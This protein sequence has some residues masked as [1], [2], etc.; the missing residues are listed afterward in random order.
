MWVWAA[1]AVALVL[2]A[3]PAG[4]ATLPEIPADAERY[5]DRV[6][7]EVKVNR[8]L[9]YG[10][11][12]GKSGE[13]EELKL[14]LYRPQGDRVKRR[15]A[16]I[17]AHGGGFSGG[18]KSEG[19]SPILARKF[20][21]MG[22]VTASINY[23]LLA[24]QGQCGGSADVPP[25]CYSAAIEAVNDGQAA[26]RFLR[27]NAKRFGVGRQ[28]VG[29]GGESA[30][31]ILAN[32]VAAYNEDPGSSGNPGYSSAVQGFMSLSGGLPD[33]VFVDELTAPGLLFASTADPVVPY[34]W[35]VETRDK[36]QSFGVPVR[37]T[38]FESDVH[39]PF[40]QYRSKILRQTTKYMYRYLDVANAP[41]A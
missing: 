3:A 10:S 41:G 16:L 23:R 40:E 17:F 2:L 21:R 4:A 26:V 22:Y 30:G 6:F 25:E 1:L 20:A 11:A 34:E 31:A 32:G 27:A 5:R 29:I 8:D 7:T 9:V 36:M 35:S 33:G 13:P 15:P 24:D 14:D 28:R 37:L 39:V 19:T 12:P 18:D 38:T